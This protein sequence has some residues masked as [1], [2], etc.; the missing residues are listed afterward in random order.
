MQGNIVRTIGGVD[1]IHRFPARASD[2]YALLEE[3]DVDHVALL[4]VFHDLSALLATQNIA[5][6]LIETMRASVSAAQVRAPLPLPLPARHS[7]GSL[8]RTMHA[9]CSSQCSQSAPKRH[10]FCALGASGWSGQR[11]PSALQPHRK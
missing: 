1:N 9:R 4:D 6:K 10:S 8:A 2:A 3:V 7:S 11:T 5:H